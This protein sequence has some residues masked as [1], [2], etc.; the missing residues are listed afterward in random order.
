MSPVLSAYE[1]KSLDT[2]LQGLVF[3]HDIAIYDRS[4]KPEGGYLLCRNHYSSM[5]LPKTNIN[6]M[7]RVLIC[8]KEPNRSSIYMKS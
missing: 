5:N 3:A 1:Q 7:F 2:W 4:L 8:R 6:C